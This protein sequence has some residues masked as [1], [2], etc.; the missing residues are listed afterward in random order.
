[1]RPPAQ[2]IHPT[3]RRVVQTGLAS[4]F[5]AGAAPLVL[6]S[7]TRAA[8]AP[9]SRVNLGFIGVG[10]HG[11]GYNLKSFLTHPDCHAVAV[12]DV[13]QSRIARARDYINEKQGDKGCK[14]YDDFRDLLADDSIDAVVISTP[15]H[16]HVP[17]SLLA[18]EAGKDVFC[19]KPT[20]TIAEGRQLVN[21]FKKS[22]KIFS[23]GIE[24]RSLIHY[25]KIAQAVRN[26]AIGKLQEIHVGLPGGDI[27]PYEKPA[28]VPDDLNWNLWLGPAPERPYTPSRTTPQGW[29][30]IRDYSGGKLTDWGAHLMDTA[31]VANFAEDSGPVE[32]QGKGVIPPNAMNTVPATWNIKYTYANGVVMHVTSS[33][34]SIRFLGS[35]GWVGNTGWRGRLLASDK[36]IY[37]KE[38]A[39]GED[40]LWPMPPT[41]HRN[42]LD[43]VHSRSRDT[44]YHPEALHRLSTA[45]HLGA[46]SMELGRKLKWDPDTE[47]FNDEDANTLRSRESREGWK[48]G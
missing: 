41:E 36:N 3:R 20:L 47:T 23:G 32:V 39:P 29:R 1:M 4:I 11:F 38:Y 48:A 43:C 16:W 26:G 5:A 12:C 27:F 10:G 35:D 30:N 15:D 21:A 9:S 33:Q 42:F 34:P 22:H 28:P 31:Q 24:D 18:L 2:P 37:L 13:F 14:S 7:R 40:K 19:E 45:M 6:T 25:H 8:T 46:I 44:I 17:M